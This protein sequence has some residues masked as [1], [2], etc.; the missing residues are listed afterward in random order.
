MAITK[1]WVDEMAQLDRENALPQAARL[2]IFY[3]CKPN[4]RPLKEDVLA[5]A[6]RRAT[7]QVMGPIDAATM[8]KVAISS[9][10]KLGVLSP[11]QS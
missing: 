6:S 1:A 7:H 4:I 9:G 10:V 2:A 5:S 3:G 11:L 8:H